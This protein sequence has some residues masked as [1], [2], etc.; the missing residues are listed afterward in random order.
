MKKTVILIFAILLLL[1]PACKQKKQP[2]SGSTPTETGDRLTVPLSYEVLPEANSSSVLRLIGDPVSSA[3]N[4]NEP[5]GIYFPT[6]DE[7]RIAVLN[8]QLNDMQIK[9]LFHGEQE[10]HIPDLS[11]VR[12]PTLPEGWRVS[13]VGLQDGALT[14]GLAGPS[15]AFGYWRCFADTELFE[16]QVLPEYNSLRKNTSVRILK[17]QE[18][19]EGAI[20]TDYETDSGRFCSICYEIA[21]SSVWY[22][23]EKY[24]LQSNQN[25]FAVSEEIPRSIALYNRES[26]AKIALFQLS[27]KPNLSEF[28]P[29]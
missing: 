6:L 21:R 28:L 14:F 11:I 22:V 20:R 4:G 2:V 25:T 9:T 29:A 17:E 27:E 24:A 8:K 3:W 18:T 10:I 12:E 15:G 19:G 23:E 7:L 16:T 5:V 26:T 1:L 13:D